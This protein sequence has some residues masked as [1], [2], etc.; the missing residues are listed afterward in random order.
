MI[1]VSEIVPTKRYSVCDLARELGCSR[2]TINRRYKNGYYKP[3][4]SKTGKMFFIGKEI[5]KAEAEL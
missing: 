2:I 4:F 1:Q 5:I 3:H